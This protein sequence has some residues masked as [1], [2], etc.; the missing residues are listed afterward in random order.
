MNHGENDPDEPVRKHARHEDDLTPGVVYDPIAPQTT[1]ET[2]EEQT[3]A[4]GHKR[5][6]DEDRDESVTKVRRNGTGRGRD[7]RGDQEMLVIMDLM[8]EEATE[9]HKGIDDYKKANLEESFDGNQ[10]PRMS[11][12]DAHDEEFQPKVYDVLTGHELDRNEVLKARLNEIEGLAGM[13]VWDLAPREQYIARTGR[14]PIRGR[15]VDVK[16]GDDNNKVYRSRYVAMEIRKMD[17][18]RE[19]ERGSVCGNAPF[20]SPVSN[21]HN[22]HVKDSHKLMFIDISKAYL[23]SDVINPELYVELPSVMNLPSRCRHLKKALYGTRD[24]TKCWENDYST[25]IFTQ[26]TTVGRS[27]RAFSSMRHLEAWTLWS[28]GPR[29]T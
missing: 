7:G 13:G 11:W 8:C 21:G 29:R 4:S 19:R 16:K 20:G 12:A 2:D 9:D 3:S 14:E 17:A 23:H 22:E 1:M 6:I 10:H 27:V 15:R 24:A 26:G 28:A 18:W 25:I 5:C